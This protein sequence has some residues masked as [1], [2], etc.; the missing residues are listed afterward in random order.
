MSDP[1]RRAARQVG[2]QELEL[3]LPGRPSEDPDELLPPDTHRL[4]DHEMAQPVDEDG[5]RITCV[6]ETV[7]PADSEDVEYRSSWPDP[8]RFVRDAA[9]F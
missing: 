6:D 1:E 5:Q 3:G 7:E 2:M 4:P 8:S 9:S